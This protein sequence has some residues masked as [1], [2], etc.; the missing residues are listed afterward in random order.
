MKLL[1]DVHIGRLITNWLIA[2]GHDVMRA[3][4]LPPRTSDEEIL[5]LAWQQSR[6]VMT[7]DK[8]F[9]ELVFR[10]GIPSAGVILLR[11][12]VP[13]EM[14]RFEVV[15]RFWPRIEKAAP[16]HF[17]VVTSRGVRRTPLP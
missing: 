9:G 7:S 16:G 8:D 11:I 2:E 4:T 10:V 13:T 15:K 17:L 3:S 6:I 12:D 1:L 5:R 14:E